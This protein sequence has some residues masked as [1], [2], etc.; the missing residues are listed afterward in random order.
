MTGINQTLIVTQEK[1]PTSSV[2]VKVMK[3]TKHP[4]EKA[5][6]LLT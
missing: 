5:H 4:R 2:I 3:A 1:I 6:D